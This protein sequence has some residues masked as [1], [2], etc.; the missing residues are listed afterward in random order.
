MGKLTTVEFRSPAAFL[1][2]KQSGAA[3]R[4]P[5]GKMKLFKPA[6]MKKG[7][8]KTSKSN[9]CRSRSIAPLARHRVVC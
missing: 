2:W 3:G 9:N 4:E 1:N 7:E 8:K 6:K 5:E